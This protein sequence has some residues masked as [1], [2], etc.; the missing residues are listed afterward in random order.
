MRK[1][2]TLA[3]LLIFSK[4]L[5]AQTEDQTIQYLKDIINS[6][7]VAT[8]THECYSHNDFNIGDAKF[9]YGENFTEE[10]Y[11][12]LFVYQRSLLTKNGIATFVH[13]MDIKEISSIKITQLD[14]G[15][16]TIHNTLVLNFKPNSLCK[17]KIQ[18][19]GVYSEQNINGK[20][21]ISLNLTIGDLEELKRAFLHLCE[22]YGG[23]PANENL[24]EK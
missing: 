8:Y 1:T 10:S 7:P 18:I 24:F 16:G 15:G 9:L 23:S 2:F 21:E 12:H 6:Y 4:F 17:K 14:F 22:L 20:V 11:K 3:V 13:L 19:N 5:C